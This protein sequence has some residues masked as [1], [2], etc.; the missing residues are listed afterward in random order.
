MT[1]PVASDDKLKLGRAH[2]GAA[3]GIEGPTIRRPSPL[4]ELVVNDQDKRSSDYW[5][6]TAVRA[7]MTQVA[8]CARLLHEIKIS[9]PEDSD[10][11][12]WGN[13]LTA[14]VLRE[15]REI[16]TAGGSYPAHYV[17]RDALEMLADVL[18]IARDNNTFA[19]G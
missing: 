15:F 5:E 8:S 18:E 14:A 6:T 11:C 9:S 1:S 17:G 4:R 13:A 12:Q 7:L 2:G 16:D 10:N 3:Y 19:G